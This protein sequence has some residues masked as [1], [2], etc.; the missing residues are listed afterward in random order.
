MEL[1]KGI[2]SPA[3]LKQLQPDQFPRLARELREFIINTVSQTGGHLAPSLGVVEL[4]IA[5]HYVF[6]APR[7]KII[8]DV[9]HQAYPHKILTGRRDEFHTNRQYRGISGFPRITESE[10]DTYGT[11]H[12]STAISSA[13]GMVCARDFRGEDYKVVAVVGDGAMTGGLAFEGLNNAGASRKDFL[14]ILNDNSMAISPSVGALSRY[15]TALITMPAFNKLKNEVWTITGKLPAGEKIRKAVGRIDGGLKAMIAPGLLFERLG[16]R[17]FGPTDGHDIGDLIKIL[18]HI[19]N[20]RGPILL[21][22]VTRKGE[23][24]PPAEEDATSFHGVG[25]FDKVT[26]KPNS[27]KTAPS[28]S[29]VFGKTLV[30]LAREDERIV[31]ITAAMCTGTGLNYLAEEIPE[32]FYDVGIAEQHAVTFA[33]GLAVRGLKPVV[34]VYSTFLQRAYDQIIHDV[35]LQNLPVVFALDRGGLVGDDGP[36]HHGAFD[37]SYLRLIP[38]L[39]IMAPADENE[40]KDMLYTAIQHQGPS[41]LRYP[42]GAGTGCPIENEFKR[43]PIGKGRIIKEGEDGI[44]LAVGPITQ[45]CVT[46]TR[47]LEG[48]GLSLGVV[49]LRFIKPLDKTLLARIFKKFKIVLTVEDNAR[50]GGLGSAVL[51]FM[52]DQKVTGVELVRMG[53]PDRFI[54][55]GSIPQ[56]HRQVGLDKD[57]ILQ[58]VRRAFGLPQPVGK[59]KQARVLVNP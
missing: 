25:S 31:G 4:T 51:E 13:F 48:E 42:R 54:E 1:L 52:A 26:G 49:N 15:L 40:L 39:V 30:R 21:H 23:G 5:L 10:Y 50:E 11:G 55:H 2:N 58:T 27:P 16:F 8:W 46:V 12:A 7:D 33:A 22:L 57:G 34:A 43:I 36:T 47:I 29:E 6:D 9:G 19:K 32:R 24:Y 17:Y 56:L 3:D 41:A 59:G 18:S 35:A 14:V 37:L 38:N 44:I 53:L 45:R 28:Y 20:L